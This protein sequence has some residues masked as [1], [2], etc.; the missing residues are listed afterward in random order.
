MAGLFF[1]FLLSTQSRFFQLSHLNK[2][3]DSMFEGDA[4]QSR[5]NMQAKLNGGDTSKKY[6]QNTYPPKIIKGIK[7]KSMFRTEPLP[8][9]EFFSRFC[10]HRKVP[11]SPI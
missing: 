1:L 9:I 5:T 11:L 4:Y 10:D 3:N 8:L 2:D 6:A 7:G